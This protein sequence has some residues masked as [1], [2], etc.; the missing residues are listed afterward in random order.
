MA[1]VEDPDRLVL[2]ISTSYTS[3]FAAHHNPS[4]LAV[5]SPTPQRSLSRITE[6]KAVTTLLLHRNT[7]NMFQLHP[8]A[9]HHLLRSLPALKSIIYHNRVTNE[10]HEEAEPSIGGSKYLA[11]TPMLAGS[12]ISVFVHSLRAHASELASIRG[13][14]QALRGRQG[15]VLSCSLHARVSSWPQLSPCG[16]SFTRTLHGP[17]QSTAATPFCILRC[18][19]EALFPAV[20][21]TTFDRED[22][23]YE[24]MGL[25]QIRDHGAD[26]PAPV[27]PARI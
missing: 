6:V 26:I 5:P 17:S 8:R 3:V 21:A 1:I 23:Q 11:M 24:R 27:L 14:A 4:L 22:R 12:L 13:R 25:E 19:R 20:L 10:P 2:E 7:Y 16:Q 18:R 9:L 15:R